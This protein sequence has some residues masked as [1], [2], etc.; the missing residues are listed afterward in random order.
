MRGLSCILFG[1]FGGESLG[2]LET[3]SLLGGLS[4]ALSGGGG[5]ASALL[6]LVSGCGAALLVTFL[7]GFFLALLLFPICF[8]EGANCS[9]AK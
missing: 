1:I 9:F 2:I 7:L 3:E 5:G 8:L 4:G 6:D